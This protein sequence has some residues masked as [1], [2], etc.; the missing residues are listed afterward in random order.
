[1]QRQAWADRV[2]PP[3]EKL[4]G[5][6]WSIPITL[7]NSP[8]RYTT[9]YAL[10]GEC[11]VT[12]ID[13]GWDSEQGWRQLQDGLGQFGASVDDVSGVLVTHQHFDH[14]GLARRIREQTGAWVGLHPADAEIIARPDFREER[15]AVEAGVRWLIE[16]G[17]PVEE[18]TRL[19][20]PS[21]VDRDAAFVVPD[22]LIEDNDLI[23]ASGWSLRAV[24][25][26]GHTPGHLAFYDERSD[27]LFGGDTILPRISPNVSTTPHHGLGDPS[28]SADL[29]PGADALGDFLGSLDK[30]AEREPDEVLPAHEWRFRGV[31]ARV[32][33]LKAHHDKRLTE[34]LEAIRRN[35]GSVPW[36]M[37]AQMTWSRPWDQYDGY[38]RVSAVGET[39]A[40][41][42]RLVRLGL[43]ASSAGPVP[44][45]TVVDRAD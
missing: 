6:L 43:V 5:D 22:R 37:A 41:L 20:R 44:R 18:A 19:R 15:L 10:A 26:P 16:L 8:L 24:H 40:H 4:R 38:M 12:L 14:I 17:A 45:Y 23:E 13:A 27:L 25:T 29:A 35:P 9:V 34:L 1:V 31:G 39:M 2:Q 28:G 30:L 33:Q 21:G 32:E 7:P 3:V 36:D 11:D 42:V